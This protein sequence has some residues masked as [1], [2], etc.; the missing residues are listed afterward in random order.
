MSNY[1]LLN[2]NSLTCILK[3]L[4][5]IKVTDISDC[6]QISVAQADDISHNKDNRHFK[7]FSTTP[8]SSKHA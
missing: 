8:R 2:G 1:F 4:S 5:R 3:S 6:G 7:F